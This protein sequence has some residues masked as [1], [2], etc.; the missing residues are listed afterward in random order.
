MTEGLAEA[1]LH[2]IST[3]EALAGAVRARVLDGEL[4]PGTQLRE[5]ALARSYG[6]ARH[7]VRAALHSLVQEGLL[8]HHRNRGVFVPQLTA[9]DVVDLHTLRCAVE[10]EAVAL[11]ARRGEPLDA[12]YRAFS[13]LERAVSH[14]PWRELIMADL[15]IHR[16][17]VDAVGSRRLSRVHA[18]L[19]EELRLALA[20]LHEKD[21]KRRTMLPEHRELIATIAAGSAAQ[22]TA[23]LRSHLDQAASDLAV[24]VAAATTETLTSS[25][26][27]MMIRHTESSGLPAGLRSSE[28][29][30]GAGGPRAARPT[31]S[32]EE[33]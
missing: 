8:R 1:P 10:S 24:A 14:A 15:G 30:R 16:A 23:L 3:V 29:V 2:R 25:G 31:P 7:G 12:V 9:A 32:R 27:R 22:A 19:L 33:L 21:E 11:L 17:V 20:A 5:A 18:A 26:S 28:A 4:A 13:E 6:V